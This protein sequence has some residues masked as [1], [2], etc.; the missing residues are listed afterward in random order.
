MVI[1]TPGDKEFYIDG[2]M[3]ENLDHV[4]DAVLN[5]INMYCQ[6]IDGR[7]G[8]GKSTLAVQ[9]ASYLTDGKL[10]VDDVC[11]NTEQFLTRL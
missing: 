9:M 7:T 8:G 11:F 6:L 1:V 4:K 2:Y 5:K 3:K 10:S